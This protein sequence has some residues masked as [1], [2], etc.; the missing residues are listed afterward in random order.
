MAKKAKKWP[1][2]GKPADYVA[3]A[4]P[5]RRLFLRLY[6]DFKPE[7]VT[8]T[9]KWDGFPLNYREGATC[10]EPPVYFSKK[11]LAWRDGHGEDALDIFIGCVLRVGMEQGRR[12]MFD[13][14]TRALLGIAAE[15]LNEGGFLADVVGRLANYGSEP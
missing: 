6:P 9:D 8:P 14:T 10:C 3:L 1:V 2:D 4:G 15:R 11:G 13:R 5:F 7:D 12:V